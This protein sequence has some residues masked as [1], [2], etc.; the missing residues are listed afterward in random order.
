MTIQTPTTVKTLLK[1]S[2]SLL[3]LSLFLCSPHWSPLSLTRQAL[4]VCIS[5]R[6]VPKVFP[7]VSNL[8]VQTDGFFQRRY[9]RSSWEPGRQHQTELGPGTGSAMHEQSR[10]TQASHRHILIVSISSPVKWR[11]LSYRAMLIVQLVHTN[12]WMW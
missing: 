11:C 10:Q 8:T 7:G 3:G 6:T 2:L 1:I 12:G 5:F 4:V 9:S